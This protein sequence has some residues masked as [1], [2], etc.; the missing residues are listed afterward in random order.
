MFQ[1]SDISGH[2]PQKASKP[3][4]SPLLQKLEKRFMFDGAAVAASEVTV[5]LTDGV[6]AVEQGRLMEAFEEND[7]AVASDS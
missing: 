3:K 5:N 7:K 6:D 1:N 2:Q 4:A